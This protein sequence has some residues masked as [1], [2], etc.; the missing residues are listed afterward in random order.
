M[1]QSNLN[2]KMVYSISILMLKYKLFLLN[3]VFFKFP[4]DFFLIFSEFSIF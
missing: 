2:F 3:K 1:L 4:I